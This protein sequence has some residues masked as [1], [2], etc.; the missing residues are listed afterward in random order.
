M[1]ASSLQ[2]TQKRETNG[3]AKSLDSEML[4][5]IKKSPIPKEPEGFGI[6]LA[7]NLNSKGRCG[8]LSIACLNIT[9]H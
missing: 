6:I 4:L 5:H 9:V 7:F 2:L 3:Y 8:L 1:L